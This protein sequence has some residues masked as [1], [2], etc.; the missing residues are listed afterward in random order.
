LLERLIRRAISLNYPSHLIK[1]PTFASAP[2]RA[3]VEKHASSWLQVAP[4]RR[5][6]LFDTRRILDLNECIDHILVYSY[7]TSF[8]ISFLLT[9]ERDSEYEIYRNFACS[10]G[11]ATLRFPRDSYHDVST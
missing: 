11:I 8:E 7:R 2:K 10:A 9:K 5:L 3:V 4:V 6:Y 1:T